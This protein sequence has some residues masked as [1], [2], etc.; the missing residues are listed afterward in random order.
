VVVHASVTVGRREDDDNI[1]K[2]LI[3]NIKNPAMLHLCHDRH[4][5]Y[6]VGVSPQT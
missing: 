6:S 3:K 1:L 2:V 4:L 5:N